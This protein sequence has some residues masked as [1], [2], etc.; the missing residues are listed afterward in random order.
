MRLDVVRSD[1]MVTVIASL[2]EEPMAMATRTS[3]A[4]AQGAPRI[5]SIDLLVVAVGSWLT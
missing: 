3:L 4:K 2:L 1:A 5:P